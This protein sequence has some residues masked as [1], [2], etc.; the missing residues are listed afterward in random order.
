MFVAT[1]FANILVP[2]L[3]LNGEALKTVTGIVQVVE[4]DYDL[5]Q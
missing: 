5:S 4:V 3:R 2:Q 1:T